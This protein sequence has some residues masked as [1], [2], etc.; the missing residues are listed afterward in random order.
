[1]LDK[2]GVHLFIMQLT[3]PRSATGSYLYATRTAPTSTP[4]TAFTAVPVISGSDLFPP[5]PVTVS[6][7]LSLRRVKGVVLSIVSFRLT[8]SG[9]VSVVSSMQFPPANSHFWASLR[10]RARSGKD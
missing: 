10:C 7:P 9:E 6:H 5:P 1:M 2:D 4:N 8:G 3:F